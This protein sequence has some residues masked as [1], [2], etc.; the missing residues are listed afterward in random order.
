M[1]TRAE[2]TCRQPDSRNPMETKRSSVRWVWP[3]LLSVMLTMTT[4]DG[5]YAQ[6]GGDP[7]KRTGDRV[8]RDIAV[9]AGRDAATEWLRT[10]M[11]PRPERETHAAAQY[12]EIADE[13]YRRWPEGRRRVVQAIYATK[14]SFRKR[15][16]ALVKTLDT[17]DWD[18]IE[19]TASYVV[20]PSALLSRNG[21]GGTLSFDELDLHDAV[22]LRAMGIVGSPGVLGALRTFKPSTKERLYKAIRFGDHALI[23]RFSDT[24]HAVDW[25][26]TP[27]TKVGQELLPLLQRAPNLVTPEWNYMRA[28]GEGLAREGVA[29]ELWEV[30]DGR[31]ANEMKREKQIWTIAAAK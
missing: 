12:F 29:V 17:E 26:V 8:L 16:I 25:P 19:R 20:V 7:H 1:N 5:A 6:T 21:F 11:E 13:E 4:A 27:M 15:T 9:T 23:M 10:F 18:L 22:E 28:L 31:S 24:E 3:T 30:S 14:E 2:G